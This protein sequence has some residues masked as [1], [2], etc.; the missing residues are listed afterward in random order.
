MLKSRSRRGHILPLA[1]ATLLLVLSLFWPKDAISK[2]KR[3]PNR[4]SS[5]MVQLEP[6]PVD[7]E[8]SI[9]EE[10][11]WIQV[12]Y[13]HEIGIEGGE[14]T[15]SVVQHAADLFVEWAHKKDFELSANGRRN[16]DL[17]VVDISLQL[18]N[19]HK[20]FSY[21]SIVTK[22]KPWVLGITGLYDTKSI[23]GTNIIFVA[24]NNERSAF[25]RSGTVA[26]EMAHFLCDYFRIYD[27]YY[28]L[29]DDDYDFEGPADE[30]ER[31]FGLNTEY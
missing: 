4:L 12:S 28:H 20:T 5:L 27:N 8:I 17:W 1:L 31:Y 25:L 10:D 23:V 24:A 9:P 29:K 18:L 3:A 21:S 15:R 13:F 11:V 22:Q 7:F 6:I 16:I 19:D 30:F 14:W 26:H 2:Q